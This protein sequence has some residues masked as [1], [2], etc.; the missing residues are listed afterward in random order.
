MIN[1]IKKFAIASLVTYAVYYSYKKVKTTKKVF[2]KLKTKVNKIKNIAVNGKTLSFDLDVLI[3][4]PT[5][6]DLDVNGYTVSLDSIDIFFKNNYLGNA[7][8]PLSEIEIPAHNQLLVKNIKVNV[9]LNN[10]LHNITDFFKIKIND[11]RVEAKIKALG[12]QYTIK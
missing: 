5:N 11:F 4:N 2:N 7:K 6:D 10:V 1:K 3:Y 12:N 9:S 8:T